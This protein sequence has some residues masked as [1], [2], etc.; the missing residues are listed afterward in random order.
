MILLSMSF[1]GCDNSNGDSISET[2]KIKER[3]MRGK[4]AKAIEGKIPHGG[5]SRLYG[6]DHDRIQK[7]RIVNDRD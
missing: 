4:K 6:Y 1:Y 3:T 5:F 7:K 2:E